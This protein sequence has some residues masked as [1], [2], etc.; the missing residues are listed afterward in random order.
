MGSYFNSTSTPSSFAAAQ[1]RILNSL[2]AAFSKLRFGF[3]Y[4]GIFNALEFVCFEYYY[5]HLKNAI[6]WCFAWTVKRL[7]AY[8]GSFHTLTHF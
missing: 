5:F 2:E 8:Y 6:K 4:F 1:T 3:G 7:G